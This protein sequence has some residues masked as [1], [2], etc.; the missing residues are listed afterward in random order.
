MSAAACCASPAGRATPC[1]CA[2]SAPR[3][4]ARA[5]DRGLPAFRLQSPPSIEG[6]LR[7]MADS[8]DSVFDYVIVGAG[9]AGCVMA[10]RLSENGQN[11]VA[12]VEAGP[13]DSHP[14]IHVP[15]LVGA[16]IAQKHL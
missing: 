8:S 7:R 14:F 6:H 13:P 1:A 2:P 15:A 9:T 5:A 3:S 4:V 16:A 12:L 11:R 10:A